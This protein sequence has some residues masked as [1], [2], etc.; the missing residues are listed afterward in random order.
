MAVS[1]A[2]RIC[3]VHRRKPLVQQCNTWRLVPALQT[4]AQFVPRTD[5]IP[6]ALVREETQRR[7]LKDGDKVEMPAWCETRSVRIDFGEG[8]MT[9]LPARV[10]ANKG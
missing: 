6:R 8:S 7:W 4:R 10:I 2:I 5:S 9:L 3:M 1:G